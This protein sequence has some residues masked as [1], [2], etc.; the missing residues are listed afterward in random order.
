MNK[1]LFIIKCQQDKFYL[2]LSESFQSIFYRH[3]DN[4]DNIPWLNLY[5]PIKLVYIKHFFNEEMLNSCVIHYMYKY[6][7][8]NIRGGKY[9]NIF[10][11]LQQ[12]NEIIQK[13]ELFV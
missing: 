12:Y 8:E 13:F 3:L 2:G 9:N 10:L 11:N 4:M 5:K 1:I 6:G 7:I